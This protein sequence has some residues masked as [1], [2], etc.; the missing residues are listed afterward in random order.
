LLCVKNFIPL[1]LKLSLIFIAE[2]VIK[3]T[4]IKNRGSGDVNISAIKQIVRKI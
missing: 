4:G 3:K 2:T 1:I